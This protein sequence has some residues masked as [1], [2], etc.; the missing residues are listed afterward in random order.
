MLAYLNSV[1][2]EDGCASI[3]VNMTLLS[4]M[5]GVGRSS[6]YRSLDSLENS[7]R[8]KRENN[9]IKVIKIEK[10]S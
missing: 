1:S 10:N 5:L 2:G 4:K 9:R 8:I 6:L 7:G 3:P